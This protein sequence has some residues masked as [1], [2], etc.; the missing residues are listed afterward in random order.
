MEELLLLLLDALDRE[1]DSRPAAGLFKVSLRGD[2]QTK[3]RRVAC[4]VCREVEKNG[5]LIDLGKLFPFS[6]EPI[7]DSSFQFSF[8]SQEKGFR[9]FLPEKWV[10]Y[11]SISTSFHII[12]IDLQY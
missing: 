9:D 1:E 10:L 2:A 12:G 11:I 7:E 5:N 6:L 8:L 4:C 3:K